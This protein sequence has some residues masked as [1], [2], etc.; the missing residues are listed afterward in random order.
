MIIIALVQQNHYQTIG[1]TI[2]RTIGHNVLGKVSL[3][4]R[5]K[6]Y[7]LAITLIISHNICPHL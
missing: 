7:L 3:Q 2:P 6:K 4:L 1:N 5:L